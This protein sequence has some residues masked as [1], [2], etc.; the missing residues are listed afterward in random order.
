MA[1]FKIDRRTAKV[2][3]QD[4]DYAGAEAYCFLD[5]SMDLFLRFQRI[6]AEGNDHDTARA[7]FYDFGEKILQSWNLAEADGTVIPATGDGFMSLP[8]KLATETILRWTQA[9]G[10]VSAPLEDA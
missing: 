8:P 3:F 10:A 6:S 2:L 5:V 1:I 7:I 4:G 9:V